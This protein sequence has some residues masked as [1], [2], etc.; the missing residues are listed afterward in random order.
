[1]LSRHQVYRVTRLMEIRYEY[2]LL[3]LHQL[4]SDLSQMTHPKQFLS[5]LG[6]QYLGWPFFISCSP[7]L[8]F[9]SLHSMVCHSSFLTHIFYHPIDALTNHHTSLVKAYP[10]LN[11]TTHLLPAP[12]Q[13]TPAVQNHS[14]TDCFYFRFMTTNLSWSLGAAWQAH[15]IHLVSSQSLKTWLN[16]FFTF[17]S[18]HTSI[19]KQLKILPHTLLRK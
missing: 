17:F 5:T 12:E 4:I 8:L 2:L 7:E 11:P 15:F 1:M 19:S 10:C 18:L 16:T 9:N 14:H 13:L 3:R 6:F